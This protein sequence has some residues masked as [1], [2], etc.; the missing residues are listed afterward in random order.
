MTTESLFGP[1]HADMALVEERLHRVATSAPPDL[2]EQLNY[3]LN[4]GGKRVRPALTLLAGSFYQYDIDL[5]LP[6]AASIEVLHTATLV[7]DDTVDESDLRRGRLSP[8]CLW[9]NFNAVL[10]GDYLFAAAARMSAETGNVRVIRLFADTLMYICTGEIQESLKPFNRERDLYLEAIGNKTASLIAAA[11]ESGAIL[12]GAP[13]ENIQNLRSYGYNL[14]M[15]FQIID[16]ILDFT[17]EREAM[18]KPVAADLARGVF[19][20]PV[21]MLLEKPEN[22]HLV[23]LVSN[24]G[25]EGTAVL[26]EKVR[27]SSIIQ[28]CFAVAREYCHSACGNLENLPRKPA[29]NYLKDLVSFVTE[30]TS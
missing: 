8:H 24:G 12:S 13:E 20:L 5:L 14:G 17:G 1:I 27:N 25:T 28:D 10:L 18:G 22:E 9:G 19:T 23:K 11:T 26:M 15:A 16:D 29:Y 2:F 21:I 4:S 6:T 7:H 30:R 3:V